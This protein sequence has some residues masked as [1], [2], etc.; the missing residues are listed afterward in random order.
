MISQH[1]NAD[2]RSHASITPFGIAST[3]S[4][5]PESDLLRTC[6]PSYCFNHCNRSCIFCLACIGCQAALASNCLSCYT[7]RSSTLAALNPGRLALALASIVQTGAVMPMPC[8]VA[9]LRHDLLLTVRLIA[10]TDDECPA[11]SHCICRVQM[12]LLRRRDHEGLPLHFND[13]H[14]Q[15]LLYYIEHR[16]KQLAGNALGAALLSIV[17]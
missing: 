4:P 17:G 10:P 9:G 6:S 13:K 11:I 16:A 15:L 7:F 5:D 3:C 1:L 14:A 2:S 12:Q 8:G